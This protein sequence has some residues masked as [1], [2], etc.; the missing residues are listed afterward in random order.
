MVAHVIIALD[1]IKTRKY[2]QAA[3]LGD[4]RSLSLYLGVLSGRY[5]QGDEGLII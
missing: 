1:P 3:R 2:M 4:Q 5:R